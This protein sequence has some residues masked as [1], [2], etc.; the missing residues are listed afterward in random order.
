M[1]EWVISLRQLKWHDALTLFWC[2]NVIIV[3][4]AIGLGHMVAYCFP[5][6][7]KLGDSNVSISRKEVGIT[8]V[9]C[10]INTLITFAG[11]WLWK[12]GYIQMH[13]GISFMLII[14]VLVLFLG[15]DLLMYVFHISIH[16]TFLYRWVHWLHHQYADPKPIDLFVLH[17]VETI[18][19]GALWLLVLIAYPA[20]YWAVFS[21]LVLNIIF[22]VLGH[23]GAE[24]MSVR[25]QQNRLLKYFGNSTFHF[26][27]HQQEGYNFGFYTTIWDRMFGTFLPNK[28]D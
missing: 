19:F 26:N 5:L 28:Y 27:H 25:W 20:S 6:S 9:T 24:P 10:I 21:Y 18:S 2:E 14:D 7:K 13:E 15:M 11:Y 16:K 8:A 17:P 23:T 12:E 1:I 3:F 4:A 22:G